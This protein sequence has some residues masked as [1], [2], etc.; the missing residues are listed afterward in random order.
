[1]NDEGDVQQED[2]LKDSRPM[3]CLEGEAVM[4]GCSCLAVGPPLQSGDPRFRHGEGE[5]NQAERPDWQS[6][7]RLP[8]KPPLCLESPLC[9]SLRLSPADQAGSP[10]YLFY[11][12]VLGRELVAVPTM[13]LGSIELSGIPALDV[14]QHCDWLKM[15]WPDTPAIA[16]QMINLQTSRDRT[17]GDL[18]RKTMS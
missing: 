14:F 2:R 1:M 13:G 10:A 6:C 8:S 18:I 3:R 11:D 4:R 9:F 15:A 12:G 17:K 7:H 16:A 5:A